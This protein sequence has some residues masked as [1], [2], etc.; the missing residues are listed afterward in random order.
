MATSFHLRCR[1][2]AQVRNCLV[3]S[4]AS[5]GFLFLQFEPVGAAVTFT[6]G[7]TCNQTGDTITCTGDLS[8]GVDVEISPPDTVSTLI[9]SSSTPINVS[10]LSGIEFQS[11]GVIVITS[12]AVIISQSAGGIEAISSGNPNGGDVTVTQTGD[13][14]SGGADAGIFASSNVDNTSHSP[15]DA[16]GNVAV[17]QTG[18]ITALGGRGIYAW[19]RAASGIAGSV[20]VTQAGNISAFGDG[21]AAVS[22]GAA[23]L[24]GGDVTVTQTGNIFAQGNGI[25]AETSADGHTGAAGDVTVTQSGNITTQ[26]KGISAS[27]AGGDDGTAG[28]VTVTQ[29]GNISTQSNDAFGITAYSAINGGNAGTTGDVTVTQSGNITTQGEDAYGIQAYASTFDGGTGRVAVVQTGK[30]TTHGD[31]AYAIEAYTTSD[32]GNADDVTVSQTGN[33]TTHGDEAYAIEVY[34]RAADGTAGDV[35]VTQSGDITT[36]GTNSFGVSASSLDGLVGSNVTVTRVGNL[37]TLGDGA[38]GIFASSRG[39][40]GGGDVT[41]SQTGIISTHG[42]S[43]YGIQAVSTA[44]HGTVGYVAVTQIGDII[45]TGADSSGIRAV[46]SDGVVG[47]DVTVTGKGNIT[48][49]GDDAY[50]IF[51]SSSGETVGGAVTV[52][53]TGNITTQ[54]DGAY[55]I[56]AISSILDLG[57]GSHTAGDV[58]VTQTGNITLGGGHGIFASSGTVHGTA[59]HVTVTQT[60]NITTHGGYVGIRAFSESEETS[61]RVTVT[62]TGDISAQGGGILAVSSATGHT[63]TADDVTVTQTGN[64]AT[65]ADGI[66]AVSAGGISGTAGRVT[67]NQTGEIAAGDHG[68]FARIYGQAGTGSIVVNLTDSTIRGGGSTNAGVRLEGL[69][70]TSGTLNSYG[71]TTISASSGT[72]VS[73]TDGDDTINNFGVLTTVGTV[74]LG[75]GTNFINNMF[76]ATYNSGTAINLGAGNLFT[77]EGT[78]SP[79][80][81]NT[82]A[83]TSITGNFVQSNGQLLTDI[84][85]AAGT[86]DLTT[87]SGTASLAGNVRVRSTD[88]ALGQQQVTIFSAA[89]GKTDNGLGLI[90]SPALHT[91]LLFPNANEVALVAHIDFMPTGLGLNHNQTDLANYL[92]RAAAAGSPGLNS[93]LLALVNGPANMTEYRSALNQLLPAVFLNS[94]TTSILSSAEFSNDLFSC[95]IAGTGNAFIRQD[96]CVWVR[97]KSRRFDFEGTSQ[98]IGFDERATGLSAG[99]QFRFAPDWFATVALGYERGDTETSTGAKSESDHYQAGLGLKYQTGSWLFAG[100]VSGG[101]AQFE[102]MRTIAFPGFA[103]AVAQSDPDIRFVTGQ[104]R[105]AYLSEF[106][107]WYAKPLVDMRLT[108]LDRDAVTETGGGSANLWVS[109]SSETY[110][111]ISPAVEFG[112]EYAIGL[113]TAMKPF[114]KTGVT[115]VADTHSSL[116]AGFVGAAPGVEGFTI[117]SNMDDLYADIEAGVQIFKHDGSSLSFGYKEMISD[118][119]RQNSVFAKG[120][121]KF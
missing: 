9:V 64:I 65:S 85:L 38:Y 40:T 95:N 120:T 1:C 44:T 47:G 43:A 102:T 15:T 61:G 27:S 105:A 76:G 32:H 56:F 72:A 21:I 116:T 37:T 18:N 78:L 50:G 23:H 107:S 26:G 39:E 93:L 89:G 30:I 66:R 86:S 118:Y 29:R 17:T 51:A 49:Q 36:T 7:S 81:S 80:G 97:P 119:T 11:E 68:I 57:P 60:G 52:S 77:N 54:D 73:A 74:D 62:Q 31:G 96:E 87:V 59:G 6:P 113:G 2:I 106:G 71:V 42:D 10:S 14:T 79:G 111:S 24:V 22:D 75:A 33:I 108:H 12:E 115:Y 117:D 84:N 100:A 101:I 34:S 91:S 110:F 69:T 94:E 16:A 4:L 8:S 3:G 114:L 28:R 25:W 45:T 92:N 48:T 53:Q 103:S 13:I 82:I 99:A 41:V 104:L 83:T 90:S 112:T 35:V 67:V 88:I 98:N 5:A 109:G 121:M 58:T 55:G 20:T 70:S 19:S 63:G 46:S